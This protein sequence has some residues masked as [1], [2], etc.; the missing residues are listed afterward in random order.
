MVKEI[1]SSVGL[2]LGKFR[3]YISKGLLGDKWIRKMKDLCST[4]DPPLQYKTL[5]LSVPTRWNSEY[6][7]LSRLEYLKRAALELFDLLRIAKTKGEKLPDIDD[8]DWELV[9]ELVL[10][11][12]LFHEMTTLISGQKY[13][14]FSAS[15]PMFDMA[16]KHLEQFLTALA[17]NVKLDTD[18]IDNLK[19]GVTNALQKLNSYE[20]VKSEFAIAAV[21]LDPRLNISYYKGNERAEIIQVLR[22]LL[23]AYD[24]ETSTTETAVIPAKRKLSNQIYGTLKA[25]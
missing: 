1:L 20:A 12:E 16:K 7:M 14:T 21:V 11:L 22:K 4:L 8:E 3:K 2:E 17:S 10:Q 13:I 15:I 9:S 24:N 23:V 18:V 6:L 25:N 19:E 5:V